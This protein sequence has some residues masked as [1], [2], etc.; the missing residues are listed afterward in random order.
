MHDSTSK[1]G[2]LVL[3]GTLAACNPDEPEQDDASETETE[4]SGE[5]EPS[6]AHD[7]DIARVEINQGVAIPI[8][9]AGE[10][11]SAELRN[12]PIVH[13]RAGLLRAYWELAPGFEPREIEARLTLSYADGSER[14]HS[15]IVE[16]TGPADPSTLSSSF[17]FEL[18]A[19]DVAP[20]M[21]FSI[22]LWEVDPAY[23]E[24][25]PPEVE[26]IAPRTGPALVGVEAGA[27]EMKVVL[28]PIEQEFD[29]CSNEVDLDLI[30]PSLEQGMFAGNPLNRLELSVR[31]QPL[32][33][34]TPPA[35][36]GEILGRVQQL[37]SG[38]GADDNVYYHGL[39]THCDYQTEWGGLAIETSNAI[40][41]ESWARASVGL[42]Q[43]WAHEWNVRNFLHEVGHLQGLGHVACPDTDPD[44]VDPNYPYAQGLTGVWG[45]GLF[46]HVLHDPAIAHDYMSYCSEGYWTSDWT[47]ARNYQRI[48]QLTSWDTAA[49]P[50]EELRT[51]L[52]GW[53]GED[54]QR[55]WWTV[56]GRIPSEAATQ[57][58]RPRS[59]RAGIDLELPSSR[60]RVADAAAELIAVELPRAMP[61]ELEVDGVAVP[62]AVLA[63]AYSN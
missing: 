1:I 8:A 45:Y 30:L 9:E 57:V 17:T 55:S 3:L 18:A 26:P 49:K 21:S 24:L 59:S 52:I 6:L 39:Y 10:W 44:K 63:G 56:R 2:F 41:I 38:D 43:K 19:E 14:V 37:R 42:F 23:A 7:I 16:V 27:A 25:P 53:I 32:I 33:L 36:L 28:V 31:P 60:H 5:V 11:V 48:V 47:W 50:A 34:T 29:G 46:D 20:N 22:S 61:E 4:T 54:G 13:T 35:E 58:E 62:T 12:A 15:T 40:P 51:L